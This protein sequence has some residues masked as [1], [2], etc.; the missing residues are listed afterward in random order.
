MNV[1]QFWKDRLYAAYVSSSQT[2][3]IDEDPVRYFSLRRPYIERVI[4]R[5][6]PLCKDIRIL[7]LGCGSGAFIYFLQQAGYWDIHGVDCST[8][9]VELAKRMGICCIHQ[10]D[11]ANYLTTVKDET[12][13][14]VLLIDILE[15]FNRQQLFEVLDEVLR[16]LRPGGLC[17][18]HVPNASGLYGMRVRYGDL[19]HEMA[20]TPQSLQQVC[21][22]VGFHQVKSFEE[23]PVVHGVVSAVRWLLWT[24]GSMPARLML[25]AETGGTSFILSQ[26]IL[27]TAARPISNSSSAGGI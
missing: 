3:V 25:V 14:L 23:R 5:Y 2:A 16:V 13:D 10:A 11:I 6:M 26:N 22:T 20:F 19:T 27:F 4:H 17:V 1:K 18:G 7:D 12:I 8:E 15:H 24:L 21:S 9:Q